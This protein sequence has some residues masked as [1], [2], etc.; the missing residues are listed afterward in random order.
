MS[1]RKGRRDSSV[2]EGDA[3]AER[4]ERREPVESRVGIDG[5]RGHSMTPRDPRRIVLIYTKV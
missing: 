2:R 1:E 4:P 5:F 3:V